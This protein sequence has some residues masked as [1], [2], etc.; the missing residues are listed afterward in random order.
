LHAGCA[1]PP[2]LPPDLR[3]VVDAWPQLPDPIRRAVRALVE[4][5]GG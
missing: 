1:E 2:E 4:T 5:S 3:R